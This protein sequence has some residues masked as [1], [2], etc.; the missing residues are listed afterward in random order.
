MKNTVGKFQKG[1]IYLSR[2]PFTSYEQFKIRPVV[3]FAEDKTYQDVVVMAISS[4]LRGWNPSSVVYVLSGEIDFESTGLKK[5]SCVLVNRIA[6][7]REDRLFHQLGRLPAKLIKKIEKHILYN[8][9]IGC[10]EQKEGSFIPYGKQS[11]DTKDVYSVV[12]T[13]RSDWITQGP[14]VSEFEQAVANYCQVDHAVAVNSGTSAL[15]ITCRALDVGE[16]DIVWTTPITFVASANCARY[17]GAKVDYVD[18]DPH[19]YNMSV[20]ALEANLDE[21]ERTGKLPKVVI[22]VHMCGQSCE[23]AEIAELAQRYGFAVIEDASH[24][25]G[26]YYKNEPVGNC[27]YSDIAVFSFHPVKIITT[28]EGGMAV[29]N[30]YEL[31]DRMSLL[32]SHGITREISE[33]GKLRAY[34]LE[35]ETKSDPSHSSSSKFSTSQPPSWYYQQIDLGYNY[36]MTELQAALGFSQLQRL[37]EFVAR[38]Q[39]LAARYDRLLADFP[40][41][42][43]WQHPDAHSAWHLYVIRLKLEEIGPSRREVFDYLRQQGI[44][45]NVH[46]IPVH[47]Q[48]FYQSQGFKH[49]QYPEAEQYYQEAITLP[50]FPAMNEEEQD[51]VIN[52]LQEALKK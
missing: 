13:L 49:N 12:E 37:D 50:L 32:R 47:T 18:I 42:T 27:R 45:V 33:N 6:S 25:I 31:A 38:R 5:D 41:I 52:T 34:S 28:A 9:K 20:K 51:K 15:H 40:L 43:P 4:V 23:M 29:T 35:W 36:R 19:T 8:L 1:D 11:I 46:Y 14:K 22:P 39:E 30:N 2:F 3:V 24:A 16:G 7:I 26:G 44:G 48:P 17:C 10:S 21:A